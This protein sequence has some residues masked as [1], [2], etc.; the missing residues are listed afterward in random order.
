MPPSCFA[1]GETRTKDKNDE[2]DAN[3]DDY[4]Q[5][6]SCDMEIRIWSKA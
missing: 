5:S 4:V 1:V 2:E 3:D 6:G